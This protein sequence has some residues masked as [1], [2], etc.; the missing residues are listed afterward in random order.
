MS[1]PTVHEEFSLRLIESVLARLFGVHPGKRG[2]FSARLQQLQRMGLPTGANPGRGTRFR[3]AYWQL[4]EFVLYLDLLDAGIPPNRIRV[5]LPVGFYAMGGVGAPIE[6]PAKG[7]IHLFIAFNA[8]N[9][10]RSG[11]PD[12]EEHPADHEISWGTT[13]G[14]DP[15]VPGVIINLSARL[16]ALKAAVG[17]VVPAYRS[18]TIFGPPNA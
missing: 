17:E 4:A 1:Q 16:R 7:D 11:S 10:L 15:T 5:H 18:A 6:W 8:L 12:A 9:Y 3:Y 2:T 13:A 14:R